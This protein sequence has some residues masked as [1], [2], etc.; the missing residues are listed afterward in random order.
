MWYNLYQ[1]NNCGDNMKKQIKGYIKNLNTNEKTDFQ[2]NAIFDNNTI[3]YVIN[4]EKTN[5]N[6]LSTKELILERKN[7]EIEQKIIFRDGKKTE[8]IYKMK[9]NNINLIIQIETKKITIND[10]KIIINYKIIDSN[11]KYEYYIEKSG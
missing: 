3:K 1:I 2:T 4:N 7:E 8:S 5:I 11:D 10:E 9:E 6:I